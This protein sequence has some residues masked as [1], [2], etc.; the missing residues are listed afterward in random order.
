MV[1]VEQLSLNLEELMIEKAEEVPEGESI[2]ID[3][4]DVK[5]FSNE[6][7]KSCQGDLFIICNVLCDYCDIL[8][9]K[10][11][12]EHMQGL[13]KANFEYYIRRCKGIYKKLADQMK[14]DRDKNIEKCLKAKD[15]KTFDN[16]IGEDALVMSSKGKKGL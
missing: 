16:D 13:R 15:K 11:E 1:K 3:F 9:R 6:T 12:E 8:E 2:L 7:I 5:A 10:V 14:Y 4:F